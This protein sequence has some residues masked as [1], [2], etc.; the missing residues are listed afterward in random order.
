MITDLCRHLRDNTEPLY[1]PKAVHTGYFPS[2]EAQPVK[3]TPA[4]AE[5]QGYV[6][7]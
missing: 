3:M 4:R 5:T 7:Q 6:V 2:Q 1:V